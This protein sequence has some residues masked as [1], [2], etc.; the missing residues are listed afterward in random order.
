MTQLLLP[1]ETPPHCSFE[2]LVVHEGIRQAVESLRPLCESGKVSFPSVLLHGVA[3]AGK[4]HLLHALR[5]SLGQPGRSPFIT[6]HFITP[7]ANTNSFDDLEPLVG[8][9][10]SETLEPCAVLVDDVHKMGNKDAAHL[11][12]LSNQLTRFGY[13][14]IMTSRVPP[15]EIFP[16]NAHLKS[17]LIAGLVF[18]LKSPEDSAR[19]MILDKMARDRNIRIAPDVTHYLVTHKSR[20]IG[21]LAGIIE[22]LDVASLQ[23]KRRITVPLVKLLEKE[24]II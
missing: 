14:L 1:L 10:V 20:S 15:E 11:W 16:E 19:I 5:R 2:N 22:A 7:S 12:S 3:G 23:L 18:G 13:P 17:R 21:E 9:M 8:T 4:T 6:V 24:G